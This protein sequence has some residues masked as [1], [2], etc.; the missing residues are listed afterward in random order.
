MKPETLARLLLFLL[1]AVV[2]FAGVV[3]LFPALA[4]AL[5]LAA[6]PDVITLR[7]RTPD[8]GGWSQ[9]T[10]YAVAG[11]PLRL[12]MTSDDVLHS[13]AVGQTGA[14]AVEIQPG[15]WSETSLLFDKPGRYT[16]YCAAWCSRDHWRMRGTI[17]VTAPAPEAGAAAFGAAASAETPAAAPTPEK[18]LYLRLGLNIDAPHAMAGDLPAALPSSERGAAL[19]AR[20]PAWALARATY[21]DNSPAAVWQ[22]L[23][24]D[25]ALRG[26]TRADLWDAAAWNAAAWNAVGF[27]WA[28]QTTPQALAEAQKL[29]AANCAAC[30][31]AAGKGDGVMVSGLP[32]YVPG[33]MT[34]AVMGTGA[35][36][37]PDLTDPRTALGAS[38]ALYQ[39]KLLRGGMGTGMPNWGSIFTP[40]QID[41][42]VA[43]LYTFAMR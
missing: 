43:Y 18:P 20:L 23:R 21:T 14:P 40:N 35:Y 7:A 1:L 22:K 10:L 16:F 26:S 11:Q 41:A 13:F 36:A 38:P 39:G 17:I 30:H 32:R 4:P 33:T 8:A 24:A 5:G 12:R 2:G 25:A 3:A 15:A 29:Y 34:G 31:G 9:D 28:R 19:A 6:Q 37:P 42:L 27:L